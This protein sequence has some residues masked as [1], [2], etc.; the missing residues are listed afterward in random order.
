MPLAI[1]A[2]RILQR[3]R[4]LGVR[5]LRGLTGSFVADEV[6][7][8][9]GDPVGA[10]PD[11]SGNGRNATQST[12]AAKPTLQRAAYNGHNALRFDGVDDVLVVANTLLPFTN[13]VTLLAVFKLAGSGAGQ[14]FTFASAYDNVGTESGYNVAYNVNEASVVEFWKRAGIAGVSS[15]GLNTAYTPNTNLHVLTILSGTGT[16]SIRQDGTAQTLTRTGGT[17]AILDPEAV[18]GAIGATSQQAGFSAYSNWDLMEL[19]VWERQL[20]TGE[21]QWAERYLGTKY[22]FVVA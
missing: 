5:V 9:Q 22:G 20:A 3:R 2:G 7:G 18:T 10:W 15:Q 19:H 21:A 1:G 14:Q 4:D 6:I 12:A 11:G 8:S 17:D 13:T 16:N